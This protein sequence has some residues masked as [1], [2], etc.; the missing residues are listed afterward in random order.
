MEVGSQSL[1]SVGLSL[2]VLEIC[3]VH[4]HYAHQQLQQYY[5]KT[6]HPNLETGLEKMSWVGGFAGG[7]LGCSISFSYSS[8]SEMGTFV[9]AS[10]S[11]CQHARLKS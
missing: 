4:S 5:C 1:A 8:A 9:A 11:A 10:S 7:T 2:C 3:Q 6:H